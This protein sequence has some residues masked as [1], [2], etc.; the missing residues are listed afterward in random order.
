MCCR[1]IFDGNQAETVWDLIQMFPGVKPIL[2]PWYGAMNL[3]SCLCQIDVKKTLN[4]AGI[5]FAFNGLDYI[6][7][8]QEVKDYT[9]I[10]FIPMIG[11]PI[12]G[13]KRCPKASD[14]RYKCTNSNDP[15]QIPEQEPQ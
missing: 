8:T 6:I 10:E 11:C 13:N 9:P 3:D 4:S 7:A 12:C 5:K 14:H 2:N 1:V 15:G